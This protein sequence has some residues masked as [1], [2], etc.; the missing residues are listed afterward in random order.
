MKFAQMEGQPIYRAI[1]S[2][3]Y[4]NAL[5]FTTRLEE[6][7]QKKQQFGLI[8]V[9]EI[10]WGDQQANVKSKD[11]LRTWLQ[12]YKTMMS[13]YCLGMAMVVRERNRLQKYV[14]V[15]PKRMANLY[16]CPGAVFHTEEDALRWLQEQINYYGNKWALT[17]F[18]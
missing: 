13:T 14:S 6:V 5:A 2:S 15:A 17:N 11:A 16:G 10:S 12:E 1:S 8:L 9:R 7:L 3:S 18:E 4:A